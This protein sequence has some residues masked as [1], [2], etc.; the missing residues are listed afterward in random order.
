MLAPLNGI[1]AEGIDDISSSDEGHVT[2][3]RWKSGIVISNSTVTSALLQEES[4]MN[5]KTTA[6]EL[7]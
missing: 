2:L 4:L 7:P 1:I 6:F 3:W 5:N